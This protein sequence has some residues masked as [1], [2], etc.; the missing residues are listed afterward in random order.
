MKCLRRWKSVLDLRRLR[1]FRHGTMEEHLRPC[2]RRGMFENVRE[3]S[4][5]FGNVRE[6]SGMFGIVRDVKCLCEVLKCFCRGT[7]GVVGGRGRSITFRMSLSTHTS[8]PPRSNRGCHIPSRHHSCLPS[9]TTRTTYHLGESICG[10]YV[11][12][13]LH[14]VRDGTHGASY[15]LDGMVWRS[16]KRVFHL[17]V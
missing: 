10:H 8:A 5:M 11:I 7:A 17:A 12:L 4:R 15:H 6:C 16:G 1:R 14:S 2:L 9:S 13:T 3:C